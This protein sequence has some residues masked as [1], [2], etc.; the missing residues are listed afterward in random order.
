MATDIQIKDSE[1]KYA[2]SHGVLTKWLPEKGFGF[3]TG[4]CS[5]IYFA[6][7][8]SF[9]MSDPA[10]A[11]AVG[12]FNQHFDAKE[13]KVVFDKS[14]NYKASPPKPFALNIRVTS[15]KEKSATRKPRES[16]NSTSDAWA[17]SPRTMIAR[18]S[19]SGGVETCCP[20]QSSRRSSSSWQDTRD[21]ITDSS[22]WRSS[23]TL[24]S[25]LFQNYDPG[26]S[27]DVPCTHETKVSVRAPPPPGFSA[28]FAPSA[29]PSPWRTTTVTAAAC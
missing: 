26:A 15:I 19:Q 24:R 2:D 20:V 21:S 25:A 14:V 4:P 13:V 12:S 9:M 16:R 18:N 6:H 1:N 17:P 27:A 11:A 3:I 23:A 29:P 22:S 7:N 10:T 28:R 8:R 5:T